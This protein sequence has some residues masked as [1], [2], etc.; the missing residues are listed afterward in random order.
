VVWDAALM[1]VSAL[2]K[3]GPEASAVQVRDYLA[4]LTDFP[5]VDGIYNFRKYPGRGLGSDSVAVVKYDPVGKDWEWLS[6]P[7]GEPLK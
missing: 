5:G 6:K 4:G 3:L 2:R 1:T 7:G